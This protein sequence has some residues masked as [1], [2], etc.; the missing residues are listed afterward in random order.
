MIIDGIDTS[1]IT[2]PFKDLPKCFTKDQ[3]WLAI[4]K[5]SEENNKLIKCVEFSYDN[6]FMEVRECLEEIQKN[7][8][9]T[10]KA[11]GRK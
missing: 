8:L 9:I 1:K 4:I 6:I 7:A 2:I 3:L 10:L 5:L 11:V